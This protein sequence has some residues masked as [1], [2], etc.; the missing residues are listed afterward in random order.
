MKTSTNKAQSNFY[1]PVAWQFSLPCS[2]KEKCEQLERQLIFASLFVPL[3]L[4]DGLWHSV[5][6]NLFTF[7]S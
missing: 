2:G 4:A 1:L 6:E 5:C 3:I 7:S